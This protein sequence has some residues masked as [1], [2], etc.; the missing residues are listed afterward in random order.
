MEA[1]GFLFGERQHPARMAGDHGA[2]EHVFIA[3]AETA[4]DLLADHHTLVQPAPVLVRKSLIHPLARNASELIIRQLDHDRYDIAGV[5]PP[6]LIEKEAQVIEVR[7]QDDVFL[8]GDERHGDIFVLHA[9]GRPGSHAKDRVD[10]QARLTGDARI[11]QDDR[12]PKPP[13]SQYDQ[14]GRD[15]NG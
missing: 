7:G 14:V 9:F 5:Q 8:G 15:R 12:G 11:I 3:G 13:G 4:Q 2:Q 6:I 10:E 1:R